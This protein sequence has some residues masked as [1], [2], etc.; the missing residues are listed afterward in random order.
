MAKLSRSY[1]AKTGKIPKRMHS[2][3]GIPYLESLK[4][5][6]GISDEITTCVRR[7]GVEVQFE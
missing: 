3:E 2:V 4:R 1:S 7:D 5:K 6:A